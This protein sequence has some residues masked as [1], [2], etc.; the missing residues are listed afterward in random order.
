MNKFGRIFSISIYGES[1]G[2]GVGIVLDGVTPGLNI[3][4][5]DFNLALERRKPRLIGTTKRIEE[6]VP[7]ILSG[8]LN[9]YTTGTPINIFFENKNIVSK[10]YKNYKEHPRPGHG[11]YTGTI[12]YQG[13]NDIAGGGHFSGRLTLGL[14]AAGVVADK[15]LEKKLLRGIE[16]MTRVSKLG[17]INL[18]EKEWSEFLDEKLNLDISEENKNKIV[19]EIERVSDLGDSLGGII[20]CRVKNLN[21]GYGEPFFDSLEAV[22]AHGLFS[23]P[24]VK[25]VEFG[26]GFKGVEKLGSEFNDRIENSDGQTLT[27]NSGG[28]NGGISNGNEIVFSVAIR[29]TASINKG[30]NTFNFE[31]E[32]KE[33]MEIK[34][35]HDVAFIMRVPIII[36]SIV[37]IVLADMVSVSNLYK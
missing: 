29:P 11:D 24:G 14:V 31:T 7:Q 8:I 32:Q 2:K 25:G 36:E 13:Y 22:L 37:K 1:H 30:Q 26:I 10:D 23:I 21:A 4:N 3:K 5:E 34:G 12:K 16:V 20:L 18:S 35:R 17:K 15:I 9:N 33:I 6:D 19:E 28:I 27:N